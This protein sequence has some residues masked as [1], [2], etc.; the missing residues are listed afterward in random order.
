MRLDGA[1]LSEMWR[2]G[3]FAIAMMLAC[4]G[5]LSSHSAAAQ[6]A[7]TDAQTVWRLLDYIAVDYMG[8]VSNGKVI[9]TAEYAEM[10]EFART[11]RRG[12]SDLPDKSAR[13]SLEKAAGEIET[14]IA[15]KAEPSIVAAKSR[16]LASRLLT[17]YPVP[18]APR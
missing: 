7:D 12:I 2:R 15:A 4:M 3:F 11:V 14:L 6:S 10:T 13:A 8:A 17:A 18:L 16:Q 9:S 5:A 1:I